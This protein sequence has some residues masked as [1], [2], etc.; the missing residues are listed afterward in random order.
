VA[1]LH[2][3]QGKALLRERGVEIP[4]GHVVHTPK[5]AAR[6]A[7]ELAGRVVLKIQAWTTGR[8]ALGG[9]RFADTPEEAEREA[10]ELLRMRV[11]AFPVEQ[12]LVERALE[13]QREFFVSLTIDDRARRPVLLLGLTGGSGVEERAESV[14]RLPVDV[15]RGVN[16]A[17]LREVVAGAEADD[18][19]RERIVRAVR[20]AVRTAKEVEARSLE[21]NPLVVT[22]DGSVLAADCRVTIDD[23]AVFRHAEL[24]IEIARELDHPPTDLEKIAY[25]I[26]QADHRGT[27]YFARLPVGEEAGERVIGFHGAGGGGSMMSLDAVSGA[28]FTPANFTDT[29]GNPS[30]AKV[31]AAARIILAQEGLLG[32]FGS[33]SGVA[34]QEQFHSAYGLAKAFNELGLDIP[35]L[36]RLGG[37]SEER[38]CA[39]VR[40]A[41]ADLPA[42]VEGC[43]KDDSP[44]FIAQR[45]RELV[46]GAGGRV[47]SPRQKRIPAFVGGEGA[48]SFPVRFGERWSGR[49]WIDHESCTEEA[50]DWLV[51]HN[52]RWLEKDEGKP[53]L[54][55]PAG[56]AL[57]ADTDMIAAEVECIR[58]GHP[59]L[60]VDI[61]IPGL[62]TDS[63]HFPDNPVESE[64]AI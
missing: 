28:G 2:E 9:V 50:T 3:Y 4:E 26:E 53:F 18:D 40:E 42:P 64:G 49:V 60:W 45:F 39:I 10:E 13:I 47:W 57:T 32:Y 22:R 27:F 29:S 56:D 21:I 25:R 35:A 15:H 36:I 62:D 34:S 58:A 59:V 37:N 17:R 55:V 43:T 12:V 19:R 54:S 41:C 6:A 23:Y 31:Y 52:H 33:G 11:G 46:D 48:Y 61:P 1:R 38:A 16:D 24:N 5:Q 30:S 20:S 7:E 63:P 51:E 8:A 14:Q 44:A